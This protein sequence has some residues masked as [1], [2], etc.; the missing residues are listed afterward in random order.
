VPHWRRAPGV[1]GARTAEPTHAPSGG[2][3]ARPP[4]ARSPG[5]TSIPSRPGVHRGSGASLASAPSMITAPNALPC[6]RAVQ[7]TAERYATPPREHGP[8][9]RLLP[10]CSHG[11][12]SQSS[13][14]PQPRPRGPGANWLNGRERLAKFSENRSVTFDSLYGSRRTGKRNKHHI[15]VLGEPQRGVCFLSAVLGEPQREENITSKFSENRE[16]A[17][18]V[19]LRFS[20]NRERAFV[21]DLRFSENRETSKSIVCGSPRTE[22]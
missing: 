2:R 17:F 22:T 13:N 15:E 11:D 10:P 1:R 21:V 8:R 4:G 12:G 18:V 6:A 16:R 3:R 5:N 20:E 7:E 9:L 14:M 19:D